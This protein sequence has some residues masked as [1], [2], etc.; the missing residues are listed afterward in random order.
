MRKA[1]IFIIAIFISAVII[2]VTSG[3]IKADSNTFFKTISL[4][5]V[6]SLLYYHLRI[7]SKN[8]SMSI[9]YGISYSLSIGL[10]TGP[11]GLLLYETI[12]S[13]IIY[14]TRKYTKTADPDEFIHTFYNI[15]AFVLSNSLAYYLFYN[16]QPYFQGTPFGFWVFLLVLVIATT[17]LSDIFLLVIFRLWGEIRSVKEAIKFLKDRSFLDTIKAALT[18]GLL[19]LFLAEE[20]WEILIVLF[21]LNYIVSRSFLEKSRSVQNKAERDHFE[22]MAYTD[23]LT[24]IPNRAYMDKKMSE[25]DQSGEDIGVVVADID[26]FKAINDTYNHAVG[27]KVI[28]HYANTLKSYLSVDDLLFR[29]GGEEFTLLLRKRNFNET[30][31]LLEMIRNGNND[32]QV[33]TEFKNTTVLINYSASYGLY[34]YKTGEKISIEKAYIYADHLLL[35]SKQLGKNHLRANKELIIS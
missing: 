27:D 26:K 16:Y 15:G 9:D 17:L 19:L 25:L 11:L 12:Y 13:F 24:G 18:N 23:F 30:V 22:Q 35:E 5:L 1:N 8:G 29:S 4:Y 31:A 32:S 33:V 34:Y 10:F 21:M 20:K 28:Q 6:F 14:F 3:G 2:A 7:Q